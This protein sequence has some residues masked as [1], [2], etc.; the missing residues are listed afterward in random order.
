MSNDKP[1]DNL[2]TDTD[3]LKKQLQI[4]FSSQMPQARELRISEISAPGATGMSNVT[5]LFDVMWEEGGKQQQKPCVGRLPP[6]S[7]NPL[8]PEY[9]L[10]SQYEVM[11]ILGTRTDVP[12]PPM[13]GYSDDESILGAP[14]Y[15]MERVKGEAPP[16]LPPYHQGG[17]IHDEL[18]PEQR[19]VLWNSGLHAMSQ[20]H[21]LDVSDLGLD[22]LAKP[23][24]GASPIEQDIQYWEH[25]KAW[26]IDVPMPACEAAFAWLK[27][28]LPANEAT[29]LCWGDARLSNVMF[30]D[31]YRD[32]TALLDWEMATLGNPVKDLAWW[33][34]LDRILSEGIG[35]ERLPGMPGREESITEWERYTGRSAEN[36]HYYEIF[37]ALRHAL[38]IGRFSTVQGKTTDEI[39]NNFVAVFLAN[40]MGISA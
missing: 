35:I 32:V 22:F 10:K 16:D 7:T 3:L 36:Y 15:I 29:A 1:I 28:N 14:F 17:W 31:N 39:A 21:T 5:L 37:A 23:E 4:W 38:I 20:I 24:L 6:R 2:A 18:S 12:A 40:I 13:M 8:F 30:A 19:T 34:T 26:G 11:R 27:E 25:F 33:I 9:D